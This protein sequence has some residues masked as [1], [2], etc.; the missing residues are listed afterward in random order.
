MSMQSL[1]RRGTQTIELSHPPKIISTYSVVGPKE[2]QGPLKT[3]FDEVLNDDTCGKDS[4]E[5]AESDMMFNAIKESIKRA[6]LQQSDINY[7]FAGDLL[8]QIISSSFAAREFEIPFFG[9]YGACSTMSESLSLAS[10]IMDGGF[11]DYVIAATSSHFSAAERQFRFPL[12]LG[13]QKPMTAQWTVTGA[14]SVLLTK[15]GV[16]PKVKYIKDKLKL[17]IP[18]INQMMIL[19]VTTRFCRT[20]NILVE[21]GVQIVDAIDI[22]SRALDNIIVYERLSISREHIRRGNEISYSI[23]K[24]EVFSNSFISMLRIGEESGSLDE[25]LSVTNDF[26][27]EELNIKIEK[28][29]KS[30]EPIITLVIGLIIYPIISTT[31]KSTTK[32]APIIKGKSEGINTLTQID[33]PFFAA[34]IDSFGKL[35]IPNI[36]VITIKMGKKKL[37]I[38]FLLILITYHP[39]NI[40][41]LY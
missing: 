10:L 35:T 17:K 3:Y 32:F 28:A 18:F 22:S 19:V 31:F 23:S 2:G 21:S 16:G 14:G 12:E 1:K 13:N 7:L 15:E 41:L 37:I 6:G 26:Y 9:L 36:K 20:L 8:N 39:S 29:M 24:S 5:K 11:A 33:K 27:S 25:T 4:Y 30:V 40:G 38:C 34:K